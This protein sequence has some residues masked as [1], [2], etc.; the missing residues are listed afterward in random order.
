MKWETKICI[1]LLAFSV[2]SFGGEYAVITNKQMKSLTRAEIKAIFLKKMIF[3]ED[4]KV[5][6]INLQARNRLRNKFEKE[7][8]HMSF[9]RLKKYWTKEH[10]LGH[11][12]PLS[13]K[14]QA[15]IKAFVTKVDG[16][17]GYID[18]TNIDKTIKVIYRW[19]D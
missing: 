14:S 16:A 2:V 17:V 13:M 12:A 1:N 15:S 8:L 4:V 3:V 11:R 9:T 18:A 5:V 7:L 19:R 6:P 10:Y